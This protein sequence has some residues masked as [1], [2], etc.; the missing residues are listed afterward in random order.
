MPERLGQPV[1]ELGLAVGQ[2]KADLA[3]IAGRAE[4]D[5]KIGLGGGRVR[6]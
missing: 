4:L 3:D 1:A 5:G 6:G 2:V